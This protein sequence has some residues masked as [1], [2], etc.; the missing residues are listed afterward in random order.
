MTAAPVLSL[1]ETESLCFRSSE[2]SIS[3]PPL[4]T[5]SA[6]VAP[7]DVPRGEVYLRELDD[8]GYSVGGAHCGNSGRV[9]ELK[10]RDDGETVAKLELKDD[11]DDKAKLI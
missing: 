1:A 6:S 9:D 3:S 2:K 5:R 11:E 4:D 10:G 8:N 7:T